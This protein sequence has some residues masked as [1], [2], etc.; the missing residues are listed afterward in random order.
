YKVPDYHSRRT[1]FSRLNQG[2]EIRK[3]VGSTVEWSL[4][5]AMDV[6]EP[7]ALTLSR[8]KKFPVTRVKRRSRPQTIR[9][10]NTG[11]R[12]LSGL[13][14][15][16]KGRGAKDFLVTRPGASE[17]NPGD[18]TSF[19]VAFRPR[20]KGSRKAKMIVSSSAG[21]KSLPLSGK[22]K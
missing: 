17:L 22:G 2:A 13:S 10:T 3:M 6:Y 4:P 15:R 20:K 18:G 5:F 1:R 9:I 21:L 19:R 12:M 8:L 14:V 7:A 16:G 11:E